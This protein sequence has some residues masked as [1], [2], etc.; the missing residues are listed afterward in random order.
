MK[1]LR[2]P[3]LLFVLPAALIAFLPGAPTALVLNHADLAAGDWWRL[4]TGHWVHFSLSHLAWNL[5]VILVAGSWLERVRP[6]RLLRFTCLAAPLISAAVLTCEPHLAVY[7]GLSGLAT[8]V[9]VL[10]ALTELERSQ[11]DA[12]FW[13][14]F[15]LLVAAKSALDTTSV[16]PLF[17]RFATPD[18]QASTMAHLAGLAVALLFCAPACIAALGRRWQLRTIQ[19]K[20]ALPTPA[21]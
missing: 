2:L 18:V 20:P 17:S 11:R 10:L 6:G 19:R 5:A 15:L 8:G 9:G 7:G 21:H 3:F 16:M 12:A 13:S 4:W 1:S 14:V